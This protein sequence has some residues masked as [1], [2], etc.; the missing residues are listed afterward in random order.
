MKILTTFLLVFSAQLYVFSQDLMI[1][2]NGDELKVKVTQVGVEDVSY[3][4]FDNLQ[5]PSYTVKKW[6]IYKIK[7]DN[8]TEEIFTQY[9]KPQEKI[10]YG[11]IFA[12]E[13][14]KPTDFKDKG[15]INITTFS[16]GRDYY[17][18]KSTDFIP[19]KSRIA[20]T[21]INGY[22][23]GS[24]FSAGLGLGFGGV[25]DRGEIVPVFG[26]I[27]IYPVNK[28]FTPSIALDF[29]IWLV[30][31][32]TEW[33]YLPF[34]STGVGTKY[35][36]NEKIAWILDLNFYLRLAP[37]AQDIIGGGFFVSTGLSF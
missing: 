7:F 35:F 10:T 11:D 1:L 18:L 24:A 34:V 32:R 33:S 12:D 15:F 37:K 20:V 19:A 4:R 16:F 9:K 5:G 17:E 31:W 26:D 6:D 30:R 3:K 29:G 21:T 27:H 25:I 2:R 23:F 22:Q 36:I 8:G 14:I 13:E 28:R